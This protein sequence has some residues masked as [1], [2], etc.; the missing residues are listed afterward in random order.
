MRRGG[1]CWT[2]GWRPGVHVLACHLLSVVSDWPFIVPGPRFPYLEGERLE[3]DQLFSLSWRDSS[4]ISGRAG[5]CPR[6]APPLP[7]SPPGLKNFAL[8]FQSC[9]CISATSQQV[10]WSWRSVEPWDWVVWEVLPGLLSFVGWQ[11]EADGVESSSR[12]PERAETGAGVRE[13]NSSLPFASLLENWLWRP[14]TW[15]CLHGGSHPGWQGWPQQGAEELP[16]S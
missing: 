7:P 4:T 15:A 3:L 9:H 13:L 6:P 11:H 5:C 8:P 14:G 2:A 12:N 1:L 10:G 16:P